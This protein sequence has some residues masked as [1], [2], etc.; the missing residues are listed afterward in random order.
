MQAGLRPG[1]EALH[2]FAVIVS[3][4]TSAGAVGLQGQCM[5]YRIRA[6][7]DHPRCRGPFYR[8]SK[9]GAR[10]S[11]KATAAALWSAVSKV[12]IM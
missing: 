8:P 9:R 3:T 11:T 7:I 4:H 2:G 6:P 5:A 10:F 1:H 12:R